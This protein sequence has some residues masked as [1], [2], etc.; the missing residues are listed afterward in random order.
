MQPPELPAEEEQRLAVLHALGILD[1]G[2]DPSF[3]DISELARQLAGTEI[4]IISL[5][6]RDRQW[7]KSCAGL[8]LGQQQ[9][10]RT[11]SF[12]GHTILQREPLI[13]HDALQD[14]RFADNPLVTGE[15]E[16][17]F[18]AGF[19][20][21]TDEGMAIGSL[22]AIS[23]QPHQLRADQIAGLRRLAALTMQ[24]LQTVQRQPALFSSGVGGGEH[25]EP[26]PV[27]GRKGLRSLERLMHR[28]QLLKLLDLN[29]AMATG[30]PLA[31]LRCRFRDYERVAA[32]FGGMGAEEF[33]DE[34]ARRLIAALPRTATVAR[35]ADAELMVML[36]FGSDP[37]TVE[38]VAERILALMAQ[39]YRHGRQ[40]LCLAVAIGIALDHGSYSSVEDILSDTSLALQ[41]ASRNNGSSF[42]FIDAAARVDARENYRLESDLRDALEEKRLEAYLQ[43]VIDLGSGDPIGFEALARWPRGDH[44]LTPASFLPMLA[45]HGITAALDL[46]I[47]EK[48]L[49]AMPLLA[50]AVPGR[51][52]RMSVNLSVL[53]L[54]DGEQR[55]RLLTL[56]ADNPCPP[57]W[58]LQVEISED[59]LRTMAAGLEPFLGDLVARGVAIA[60]DDFGSGYSSLARLMALPIQRVK[61]DR[62]CVHN[63]HSGAESA[64]RL[65]RTM[66][67]MLHGL[68][69]AVIAEGVETPAQ[70]DWLLQHNVEA[71]QGHLFHRPMPV[72]EAIALLEALNDRPG[73]REVA[74]LQ[75]FA[76]TLAGARGFWRIPR[77][78]RRRG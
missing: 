2:P 47:I 1:S 48:A 44:V 43:P 11:V 58:T 22:C 52:L 67:T 10:P 55:S 9:S 59:A 19:P 5:V 7:F 71:A 45:D 18:Y 3:D 28:D 51:P 25:G 36:P 16:I 74:G 8:P 63:L 64:P 31:L 24:H 15:P 69:L 33:I 62:A 34:A 65:L 77:G 32:S 70:R 4:G 66:I 61:I 17:R 37:R 39:R 21:L 40:A 35:F 73:P 27:P 54:E 38:R 6:D 75:S 68:G 20:L 13:I 53:L 41:L 76:R 29:L 46:L 50:W 57:G 78:D 42:R 14:P 56:L 30:A 12:C 60:I 49:A 23:R 26:L 72:S